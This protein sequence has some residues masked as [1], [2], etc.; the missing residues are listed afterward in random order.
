MCGALAICLVWFLDLVSRRVQVDDVG[1][2][3]FFLFQPEKRF[4]WDELV[5]LSWWQSSKKMFN[6]RLLFADGQLELAL[7]TVTWRQASAAIRIV[8]DH[9]HIKPQNVAKAAS[10]RWLQNGISASL[11]I[12]GFSFSTLIESEWVHTIGFLLVRIFWTRFL[13]G[14]PF[15]NLKTIRG[16]MFVFTVATL[17]GLILIASFNL[18]NLATWWFY[19]P[20]IDIV[21]AYLFQKA[22]PYFVKGSQAL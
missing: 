11:V 9:S 14:R 20:L 1:I 16:H 10:K 22:R 6:Y 2:K 7:D 12:L 19:T 17:L 15:L 13:V 18:L 21:L 8:I 4:Y 3:T 5:Q